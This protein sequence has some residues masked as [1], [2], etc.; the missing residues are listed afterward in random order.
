MAITSQAVA[1]DSKQPVLEHQADLEVTFEE[2]VEGLVACACY[3][4]PN[5]YEPLDMK[6]K[7][8]IVNILKHAKKVN[9]TDVGEVEIL[10]MF[11][12]VV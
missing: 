3:R 10:K 2:F 4:N 8:F 12:P 1:N 11:A 9:K 6:F 5:P 7:A